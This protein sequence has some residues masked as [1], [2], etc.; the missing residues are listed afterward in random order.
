MAS[1]EFS[2]A[3]KNPRPEASDDAFS[4]AMTSALSPGSAQGMMIPISLSRSPP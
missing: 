1:S 4:A 2:G 3:W